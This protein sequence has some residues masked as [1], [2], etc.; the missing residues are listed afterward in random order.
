MCADKGEKSWVREMD[1]VR[2]VSKNRI[3]KL[4]ASNSSWNKYLTHTT[5]NRVSL[6]LLLQNSIISHYSWKRERKKRKHNKTYKNA[7]ARR[8]CIEL[9]SNQNWKSFSLF[10]WIIPYFVVLLSL[11]LLEWLNRKISIRQPENYIYVSSNP[12]IN[13]V[14]CI[15]N[16][17]VTFHFL[18]FKKL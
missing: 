11:S 10:Q 5:I 4:I 17:F 18:L 3:V 13:I 7:A 2:F 16:M 14:R 9:E 6:T 15:N 1:W 8:N 12:T